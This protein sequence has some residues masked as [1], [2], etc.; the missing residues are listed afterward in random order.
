M[1]L[2]FNVDTFKLSQTFFYFCS[3]IIIWGFK[4]RHQPAGCSS[5]SR[6]S[7]GG[8]AALILGSHAEQRWSKRQ[9]YE[10][11]VE[12]MDEDDSIGLPAGIR[13]NT[14]LFLGN[15]GLHYDLLCALLGDRK[16][17]FTVGHDDFP[18]KGISWSTVV[19]F[20]VQIQHYASY[21]VI[22]L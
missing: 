11:Y 14:G 12:G 22:R 7:P 1:C 13:Y 4:Q 17:F 16:D 5:Q 3:G 2:S 20:Q 10:E 21:P 9:G 19:P 15:F 8:N 6:S 18:A